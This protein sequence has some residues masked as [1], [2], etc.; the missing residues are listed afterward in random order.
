MCV[1]LIVF[2]LWVPYA[3]TLDYSCNGRRRRYPLNPNDLLCPKSDTK[4]V[5]RKNTG[6]TRNPV[7]WWPVQ[8]VRNSPNTP[9]LTR[10]GSSHWQLHS[11]PSLYILFIPKNKKRIFNG[12]IFYTFWV[13]W[14]LGF[15]MAS[16][17]RKVQFCEQTFYSPAPCPP[18]HAIQLKTVGG[19]RWIAHRPPALC[20]FSWMASLDPD[21][22]PGGERLP[23]A[24]SGSLADGQ[25][26]RFPAWAPSRCVLCFFCWWA[27]SFLCRAFFT[28]SHFGPEELAGSYLRTGAYA[29]PSGVI[30]YTKMSSFKGIYECGISH[31]PGALGCWAGGG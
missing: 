27:S 22:K 9:R 25:A 15:G 26:L 19:R 17:M 20:S 10:D 2:L 13:A 6:H 29:F 3:Q 23:A 14:A 21:D 1:I 8:V 28:R 11:S 24:A 30:F 31:L 7:K 18:G 4:A 12:I 16:S 5:N